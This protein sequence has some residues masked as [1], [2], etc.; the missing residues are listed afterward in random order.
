MTVA[1]DE[2][3]WLRWYPA[4]IPPEID[5]P[6]VPLTRLLDD[7]AEQFP[8]RTAIAFFGRTMTYRRLVDH[9]DRF[10]SAL[11][12]VGVRRGDRVALVLPNCPQAV[13]SFYAV[14]RLGAVVVQHNPLYTVPELH[15][16]L[17]DSGSKVV[18]CYDG[19]YERVAEAR[20]G[21]AVRDIVVTSLADYLPWTKRR[22]LSLPLASAREKREKLVTELPLSAEVLDFV[23]MLADAPGGHRQVRVDPS[24]DVALLQ[25][26]GGT[27]GLPKGAMLT[28]RALV[29]NAH[30]T[31]TWDYQVVKGKETTLAVLPLFH[32]Y[33]LTLCLTTT[34]FVA[35]SLV[36]LPLFEP[37]LVLDAV[38]KYRPTI[39]PGVPPMYSKL[40]EHPRLERYDLKS[41]RTCVSGAMRLPPEVVDEFQKETGGNLVE[42][43]G[44]TESSPVALANPLNA[45]ARA[46]TVG[47]PLPS[48][49]ARIVDENADDPHRVMPVGDAG[50]LAIRGPQMF[51][52]YWGQPNESATMLRDGWLLTGDICVM[53]PGGYF[54][55]ID[56]KRDVIMASGF[57]IFPSEIEDALLEHPGIAECAVVGVPDPYRGET[58]KACIVT[59]PGQVLT[60]YEVEQ[61]CAARLTA[62]KVPKIVEFREDLPK[63]MIGKVLRR[64]LREEHKARARA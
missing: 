28:H 16:Q 26:T 24:Q 9:V 34:V 5:V 14:L 47:L 57:S 8:R 35:G 56:R 40:L 62:Y 48:T 3:P 44:L 49:E 38:K 58:V 52:G 19:V 4:G 39:F 30:Q 23:Q 12:D 64:V 37:D 18:V 55:V 29:A 51:S 20:L 46:G 31:G 59:G 54:T 63:N 21:T 36:L 22:L 17:T 2:R 13:I 1:Y 7:A 43:Y 41:I 15:H 45:N 33:G 25:Y 50:E 32:V 27:T 53:S 61:H 42:G 6:D 60:A 11:S 10:A